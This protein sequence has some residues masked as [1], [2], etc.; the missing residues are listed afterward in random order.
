MRPTSTISGAWHREDWKGERTLD[1]IK[2]SVACL[3]DPDA[4]NNQRL[5]FV[6]RLVAMQATDERSLVFG[7][8]SLRVG[9]GAGDL[10]AV[11]FL[12]PDLIKLDLVARE[13]PE[14]RDATQ[15]M[16]ARAMRAVETRWD[17]EIFDPHRDF[18][19]YTNVFLLYIR[20]LLLGGLHLGNARLVSKAHAQW[21]RW[22]F[23]V[24]YVGIDEFVSPTYD[25]V[26]MEAMGD[27]HDRT[28]DPSVRAEVASAIDYLAAVAC[29]AFHPRL[30]LF[31]CGQSRHYHSFLTVP[32][33]TPDWLRRRWVGSHEISPPVL[34][35]LE[36]R[37]FPFAMR[38]RAGIKPCLFRTW[39][40]DRAAVGSMTGGH[41]FWQQVSWIT[42]V[43][44]S[45]HAREVAW[46]SGSY[47]PTGAYVDQCDA[48]ALCVFTRTPHSLHRTQWRTQPPQPFGDFGIGVTRG[49]TLDESVDAIVLNAFDHRLFIRPFVV[50]ADR[51][52]PVK[53]KRV[54]RTDRGQGRTHPGEA[55]FDE[56]IFPESSTLFGFHAS[57]VAMNET[58]VFHGLEASRIGSELRIST[59]PQSVHLLTGPNSD[60]MQP[61]DADWRTWP[62]VKFPSLEILAGELLTVR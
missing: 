58:P 32:D 24:A 30:K 19:C 41:Y 42:A 15:P 20:A 8:F 10:N 12:L 37:D 21:K 34:A 33:G 57:L 1:F 50:A 61:F 62:L 56:L 46:A 53:L 29:G 14:L 22:F 40:T 60:I 13:T 52:I 59:G 54:H 26:D 9:G 55:D 16:F 39:Q 44:T 17:D 49:W 38:G 45:E 27:I 11:L 31:V 25:A 51:C 28:P 35:E 18:T 7:Q 3:N 5:A 36:R 47:T 2:A 4:S 23:H 43:G 48:D 6:D